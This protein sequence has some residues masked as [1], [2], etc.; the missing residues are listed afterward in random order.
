MVRI[1][2]TPKSVEHQWVNRV[3]G[4]QFAAEVLFR[5]GPYPKEYR[6]A[7]CQDGNPWRRSSS[8]PDTIEEHFT[9]LF[10]RW[11]VNAE[12]KIHQFTFIDNTTEAYEVLVN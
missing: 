7:L 5:P 4:E 6:I 3:E 2:F 12:I 1:I 11:G 8:L 9:E 10:K